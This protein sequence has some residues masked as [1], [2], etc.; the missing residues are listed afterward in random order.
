MAVLRD[1]G[2][3]SELCHQ[4]NE[5]VLITKNG[6]GYLVVMSMDTY[7]KQ[8]GMLDIYRKLGAA[9]KQLEDGTPLLDGDEVL[10]RLRGKHGELTAPNPIYIVGFLGIRTK[11][12]PLFRSRS[13]TALPPKG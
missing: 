2:K 11:S 8:M 7:G 12:T 5:P 6:S 4:K 1:T 10:K 9:E 13:A 3:I